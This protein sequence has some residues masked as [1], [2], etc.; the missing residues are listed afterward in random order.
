VRQLRIVWLFPLLL[1]AYSDGGNIAVIKRRCALRN[2]DVQLSVVDDNLRALKTLDPDLIIL[3]GAQDRDETVVGHRIASGAQDLMSALA[4]KSNLLGVCAG[5]Q[6]LGRS[7]VTSAGET[8][9]GLGVLDIET[10]SSAERSMGYAAAE[11]SVPCVG[12]IVGFE[13]HA[14]RT[15]LAK[16]VTPLGTVIFGSGNNGADRS[17]GVASETIIGT[18]LHGPVLAANP[19]L[20]DYIIARSLQRRGQKADL[21]ALDDAAEMAVHR[22]MFDKAK[23][24]KIT[25]SRMQC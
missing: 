17:E 13:N 15:H 20:A 24:R 18:Y 14:G 9:S 7:Y 1:N 5:Y 23:K 25:S 4:R 3:G 21:C 6:L 2:I 11:S 10:I 16:G 8:I 12:T 19:R 22:L